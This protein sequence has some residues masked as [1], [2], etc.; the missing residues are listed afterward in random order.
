V[1]NISFP[2]IAKSYVDGR[3]EELKG[4]I[5]NNSMYGL[6]LAAYIFV[7]IWSNL[8]AIYAIIPNGEL[9]K[10]GKYIFLILS[11][12]K[13]VDISIGSLGQL[14]T[15]SKWYMLTLYS[16]IVMSVVSI[17]LGYF[18]TSNLELSELRPPSAYVSVFPS[19][20]NFL[21]PSTK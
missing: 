8:D 20:F 5:T 9:Y 15:I 4:L 18:L 21:L 14:I 2:K 3:I 17:F 11:L 10:A 12:G 16:S 6:V 1:L 13:L 7:I 19:C